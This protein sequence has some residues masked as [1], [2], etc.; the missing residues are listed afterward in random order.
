MDIRNGQHRTPEA[1]FS[2]VGAL[3]KNALTKPGIVWSITFFIAFDVRAALRKLA[4]R[5]L[6]STAWQAA[7]RLETGAWAG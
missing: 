6:I 4:R 3:S 1:M 7:H 5:E 2:D